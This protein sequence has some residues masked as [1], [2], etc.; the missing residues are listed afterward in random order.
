MDEDFAIVDP[1]DVEQESFVTGEVR[2]RK[3]T[4]ALGCTEMRINTVTVAPGEATTPHAHE[5]HEEVYISLTG[6]RVEIEDDV[7]DVPEGGIVRIGPDP[8]RSVRNDND[9]E[10][11]VWVMVGAPPVGTTEDFGNTILPGGES[12]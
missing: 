9:D 11:H 10:T 6:G 1:E 5:G 12:L 4:D 8:L 3:L 2:H 7:Y